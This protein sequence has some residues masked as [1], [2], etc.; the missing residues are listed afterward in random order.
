MHPYECRSKEMSPPQ[1]V[2]LHGVGVNDAEASMIQ[3]S[4]LGFAVKPSTA[5]SRHHQA[6]VVGRC[7]HL[8]LV[9]A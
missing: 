8:Y 6:S 7:I 2:F 4:F 1:S 3:S 9:M 5:W